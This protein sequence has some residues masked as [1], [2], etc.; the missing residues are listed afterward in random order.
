[1][2]ADVI[3]PPQFQQTTTH[4]ATTEARPATWQPP[5]RRCILN[6]NRGP[7]RR[8]YVIEERAPGAALVYWVQTENIFVSGSTTVQGP[9][10]GQHTAIAIARAWLG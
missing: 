9:I 1:M 8:A 10:V 2:S 3:H 5:V 6:L 4:A 7:A